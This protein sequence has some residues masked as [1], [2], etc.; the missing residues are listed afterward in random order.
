M[1]DSTI[2]MWVL[3]THGETFYVNHVDANM[4]WSTK[5]TPD[6]DRTKGSL[7]FK[8]ALLVIDEDNSATLS[9]LTVYDKIRLR[10]Q[11]L[12]LTRIIFKW[13]S[14]M[15]KALTENEFKHSPFKNIEGACTSTFVI[16]DMKHQEEVTFAALKYPGS[17]RI[18][19]ANE[20]YYR[21]YDNVR[22]QT[23]DVDYSEDDTP[24]EYS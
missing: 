12:G 22:G 17:F 14:P 10:N 8:E 2:P 6:N 24:Y 13:G 20:T 3:K 15:H 1:E 5:E 16:C 7:K 19:A 9:A 21:A 23:I 18:L 4:P 11:K